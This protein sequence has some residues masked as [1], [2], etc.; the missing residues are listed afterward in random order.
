MS[1]RANHRRALLMVGSALLAACTQTNSPPSEGS[2]HSTRSAIVAAPMP[3]FTTVTPMGSAR[4]QHAA[5]FLPTGKLLV[6]G[7]VASTGFVD[8]AELFDP[9]TGTWSSAG[10]S[11]VSANITSAVL[12]PNGRV[13]VV[14]DRSQ[15]VRLYDPIAG[16]WSTGASMAVTR[17]LS[18]STLLESGKV[19]VAGGSNDATAELYDPDTDT[20]TQTG[21]MLAP[22]RAHVA[23]RLTN[24][25][26]LVVSGATDSTEVAGAELYD[27]ASGTWTAAAPPLVP[28]RYAT[29]TLL[30]DGR[31]L[32]SGGM[33]AGVAVASSELYD[34]VANTWTATGALTN[35]RQGHAA[36]LLP[37]GKVL[38]MGG[39]PFHAAP[40][41][42]AEIY[43]PNTGTWTE[44]ADL[45]TGRES[46][47]ATL[48]P[49]GKVLLVG[50]HDV[51][52]T[53]TF[54]AN[55]EVFDPAVSGWSAAGTMGT[56]RTDPL[57]TLLPSGRVL[58]VGGR[59]VS[60]EASA[61]AELVEPTTHVWS[62]AP[63]MATA[64]E[65]ATA[66]LL[67]SGK[68]LVTGGLTGSSA[69]ASSEIY[70]PSTS[71]W[72]TANELANARSSHTATLLS[73]GNVLVVGGEAGSSLVASAEVFDAAN[74]TW[75]KVATPS[76]ARSA[77]AAV[78]LPGGKVLVA[79]GRDAGGRS[80]GSA[81]IYDA[82]SNAWS[83]AASLGT[84]RASLSLTLLPSGK[85]LA[86][87]GRD[88][89]GA[90]VATAEIYDPV[91]DTWTP[92]HALV[93]ARWQHG[94]A[95][96]PSGKVLVLGGL[97][98]ES[99]WAQSAEIYDPM[100]DEFGP[101]AAP[102]ARGGAVLVTLPSG[103]AL[104]VGGDDGAAALYDDTGAASAWRP[105]VTSERPLYIGCSNVIEGSVFRGVS[106]ASGD[107]TFASPSNYAV[108][109]LRAPEGG[110]LW[111][112]AT[113]TTSATQATV[114]IPSDVAPGPYALSIFANAIP[115]GRMVSLVPNVSP[116]VE[117]V[118]ISTADGV[119]VPITLRANDPDVGQAL[120][121][122]L[123]T[124]PEHGTLSGTLP[125]VTYTPA[126][127]YVGADSFQVG[128]TDCGAESVATV[129]VTATND[130]PVIVCPA[131]SVIEATSAK[132]AN[133]T[134]FSATV[135]DDGSSK[136]VSYSP[137]LGAQLPFGDTKVTAT[138]RDAGGRMAS[139]SFT[140]T[141]K[142]TTAPSLKCPSNIAKTTTDSGLAVAFNLPAATDAVSTPTVTSS[143]ESE[144][145]FP[146]GTTPVRVF[147]EDRAGNVSSCTFY[148]DVQ[149]PEAA[150]AEA[151]DDSGCS[152]SPG[153]L[154]TKT[155]TLGVLLGIVTLG[156]L[157]RRRGRRVA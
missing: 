122:R 63:S 116:T 62:P 101:A 68:V 136:D 8:S 151:S 135:T 64:R 56:P 119:S 83:S 48:L 1:R 72:S 137:A 49:S 127:G 28:R 55:T 107:N 156:T 120:T 104:A 78:R 19:L 36:T 87:G 132:G 44:V 25:K 41:L 138:T 144:S 76:V 134:W 139:C 43:D 80:L 12:L 147:A 52:A 89:A 103:G 73:N 61:V 109:R 114:A 90:A 2:T 74:K 79:G 3:S 95:L 123:V 143:V 26:V 69:L 118:T 6:V 105:T 58:V 23:T 29:G 59:T 102:S 99:G 96:L 40:T 20:F 93:E 4:S 33:T 152:A 145:V 24:G 22:H 75:S 98:G 34:P 67:S 131:D 88:G 71:T 82:G 15:A 153:G 97:T 108:A 45:Q 91:A 66:T 124:P 35:A 13:L 85:V 154:S 31:V 92:S 47:T 11:G 142:D 27:P 121:W 106:S 125:S 112:L 150:A 9:A 155:S 130:A 39:A 46:A 129:D 50:G 14:G 128:V 77:H 54:F 140:V 148:V 70:D 65:H 32:L 100:T 115:G 21:S 7:G 113:N 133:A 38:V 53:P 16:T 149:H 141:V 18:T 17:G 60:G 81:E 126:N 57:A 10:A 42:G 157:R 117:G 111:S 5:V 94:T 146:I 110:A 51:S 84:A 37:N 30:P 86:S